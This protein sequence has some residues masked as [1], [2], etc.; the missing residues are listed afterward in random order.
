MKNQSACEQSLPEPAIWELL[1]DPIAIAIMQRDGL[2]PED[3]TAA[4]HGYKNHHKVELLW[5]C[6]RNPEYLDQFLRMLGRIRLDLD[7]MSLKPS[8]CSDLYATCLRC[9]NHEICSRWLNSEKAAREYEK[10]CPNAPMFDRL[11]S[12]HRWRRAPLSSNVDS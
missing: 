7:E 10:F 1:S 12:I 11:L 3:V 4:F 8:T 9:L 5:K 6:I 2:R